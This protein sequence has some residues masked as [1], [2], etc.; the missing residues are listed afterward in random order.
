MKAYTNDPTPG[1]LTTGKEYE[2]TK[3]DNDYHVDSAGRF[4]W[5]VN[6]IGSDTYSSEFESVHLYGGNWILIE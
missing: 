5:F 1:Y 2:V 6:D 3:V 4:F